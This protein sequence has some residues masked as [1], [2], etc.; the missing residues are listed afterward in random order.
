[1]TSVAPIDQQLTALIQR[2]YDR[3]ASMYDA[4]EWLMEF[5][6]RRWRRDLWTRVGTGPVLELGIGTGKSIAFYP[7]DREVVAIDISERMLARAKDRA[8]HLNARVHL[9][10]GDAQHLPY[11]DHGFDTVVAT[12]LFCSV[13]DPRLG[14]SEA[15]RVLKPGGHLLLVEH[16]LS[17]RPAMARLMRWLAPIP[18]S[19]WGAHIDRDTVSTV[20]EAGFADVTTANLW[21][22]VVQRIDARAPGLVPR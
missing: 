18:F 22:D 10:L 21:G 20:R 16:V 5:K 19:L 2:R 8:Y 1:M 9:D 4:M 7:S 14:L 15:L 3:I 6:A 11:P 12:F 17:K 13:P